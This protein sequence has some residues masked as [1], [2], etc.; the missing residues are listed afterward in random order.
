[1]NYKTKYI[2]VTV[3]TLFLFLIAFA[4]SPTSAKYVYN[5]NLSSN[6]NVRY[7]VCDIKRV[8]GQETADFK[9]EISQSFKLV[10][11]K[12][13]KVNSVNVAYYLKVLDENKNELDLQSAY[14]DGVSYITIL[15]DSEGNLVDAS[16][17]IIDEM[18]NITQHRELSQEELALVT[19]HKKGFGK[20]VFH[21]DG[22][23]KDEQDLTLKMNL[24]NSNIQSY[25][26]YI[27]VYIEKEQ[28]DAKI[29]YKEF[30]F[31]IMNN[32][33]V[34][35]NSAT[36]NNEIDIYDENNNSEIDI[37]DEENNGAKN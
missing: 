15:K 18:E 36:S 10:N 35:N 3:V 22:Q 28:S 9:N 2:L 11:Y 20:F 12:N 7:P 25:K 34:D 33:Q 16:G 4:I 32:N 21:M 24:S 14:F 37:Y 26:Y 5:F 30:E 6:L 23:T 1:M 29:K 31:T 8:E 13:D 17:N 27:E 19:E